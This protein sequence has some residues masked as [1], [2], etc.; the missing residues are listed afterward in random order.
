MTDI[1]VTPAVAAVIKNG[2]DL[3]PLLKSMVDISETERTLNIRSRESGGGHVLSVH[4]N[5]RNTHTTKAGLTLVILP[6]A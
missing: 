6:L 4:R 5:H 3:K 2:F 1:R